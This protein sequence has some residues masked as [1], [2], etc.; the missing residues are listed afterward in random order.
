[1][2]LSY[3]ETFVWLATLGNFRAVAE[4]QNLTQPAVSA[5]IA[6][7]ERDLG[8]A[9]FER[10]QR[11]AFLTPKGVELLGH[12]RKMIAINSQIRALVGDRSAIRGLLRLGVSDTIAYTW[13]GT[14]VERINRDYPSLTVELMVDTTQNLAE[15]LMHHEIDVACILGPISGPEITSHLLSQFP[16]AWVASPKLNLPR[17]RLSMAELAQYPI[18][19]YPRRSRPFVII[20]DLFSDPSLP[21]VKL[22]GSSSLATT[23]RLAI[24]GL[25]VG[26][27]PPMVVREELR[28]GLLVTLDVE[29]TLPDLVFSVSYFSRPHHLVAGH[30]ADLAVEVAEEFA[31][32][33]VKPPGARRNRRLAR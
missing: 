3:L 26:A 2:R 17:R 20:E 8:V 31:R 28:K 21:P 16:L 30:V 9:L 33:V 1:M 14:L 4:R 13:L 24:D 32:S 15:G 7:L 5:R 27:I 29:R 18:I 11:R 6:A 23:I 10:V 25:G 22:N 12:A 19:T